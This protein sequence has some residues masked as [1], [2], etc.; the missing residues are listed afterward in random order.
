MNNGYINTFCDLGGQG[1]MKVLGIKCLKFSLYLDQSS[2]LLLQFIRFVVLTKMF[3]S[4]VGFDDVNVRVQGQM[5]G[6]KLRVKVQGHKSQVTV[7]HHQI[8]QR[9]SAAAFGLPSSKLIREEGL[10][11]SLLVLQ[12]LSTLYC[13][14]HIHLARKKVGMY[15]LTQPTKCNM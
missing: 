8:K 11:T 15:L 2:L 13:G 12:P 7:F 9:R 4:L 14:A 1:H 6:S 10:K 5:S 3:R